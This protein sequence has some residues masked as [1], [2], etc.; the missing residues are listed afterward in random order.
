MISA[1]VLKVTMTGAD[2]FKATMM[3]AIDFKAIML[4][5]QYLFYNHSKAT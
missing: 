2:I 4:Y 5:T 1:I 3:G